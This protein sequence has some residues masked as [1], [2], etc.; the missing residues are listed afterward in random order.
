MSE[1]VA[2][3]RLLSSYAST[4]TRLPLWHKIMWAMANINSD[5]SALCTIVYW[6]FLFDKDNHPIDVDNIT[7]HVLI[8]FINVVDVFVSQR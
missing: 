1:H 7:G 5:I 3:S 8:M 2:R 4:E 6:F